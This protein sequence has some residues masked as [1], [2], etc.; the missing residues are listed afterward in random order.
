MENCIVFIIQTQEIEIDNTFLANGELE[1]T[2][3]QNIWDEPTNNT[4][5]VTYLSDAHDLAIMGIL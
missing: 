3:L 4:M 2:G 1:K 5:L